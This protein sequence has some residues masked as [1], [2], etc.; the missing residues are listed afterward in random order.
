MSL[1]TKIVALFDA[2]TLAELDALPPVQRQR[3][4]QR[5][6]RWAELAAQPRGAGDREPKSY[7]VVFQ[8]AKEAASA[9][10]V[11]GAAIPRRPGVLRDL[12]LHPREG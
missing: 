9:L 10:T 3:L 1:A 8:R 7:A 2:L 11:D 4:E 5:C 12:H 6:R